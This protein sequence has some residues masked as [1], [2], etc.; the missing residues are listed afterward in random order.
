MP[1]AIVDQEYWMI[2]FNGSLIK[3]GASTGIVFVLPLRVHMR[4]M[5]HLH[6][7]S[8]NNVAEYEVLI[9]DLRI[10][11]ELGIRRLDVWGDSR[12][13]VD[14]VMKESSCHDTKMA[15]YYQEV[16]QLEDK[17]NGHELNHILRCLNEA[18]GA[19][20]KAVSDREL[21]PIGVFAS[22]NTSP[23]FTM[24]GWNKMVMV[25]LL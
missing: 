7:P 3:R 2:Y 17:L 10:A 20:A 5:V 11:I 12:L 14:Q 15:M 8:S 23:W 4:Y 16:C 19:L 13:V 22:D 1:P 21:A 18:A 24:R 9:N 25:H 6:F